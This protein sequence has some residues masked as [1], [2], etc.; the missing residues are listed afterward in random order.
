MPIVD[1]KGV[2]KV[3]FPDTWSQDQIV[4][5]IQN[6]VIPQHREHMAKTGFFPALKAGAREFAAGTAETFGFPEF[7]AEQRR[8]AEEGYQPI[9]PDRKST[10]L[11]SSH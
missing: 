9:T 11:N 5:A 8:K 4:D 2:G 6:Q 7:G 10:R 1:I 3:D